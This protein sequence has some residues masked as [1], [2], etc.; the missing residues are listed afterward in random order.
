MTRYVRHFFTVLLA[1]TAFGL[2]F[3]TRFRRRP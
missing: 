3:S 1:L 2:S